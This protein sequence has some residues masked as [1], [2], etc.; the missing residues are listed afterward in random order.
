MKGR[1][2]K[3]RKER[4]LVLL[5]PQTA[6]FKP[7][8][9]ERLRRSGETRGAR[10]RLQGHTGK[11]YRGRGLRRSLKKT[12]GGG[13]RRGRGGGL[14]PTAQRHHGIAS[15]TREKGEAGPAHGGGGTHVKRQSKYSLLT[16]FSPPTSAGLTFFPF[17]R[18][19]AQVSP[20]RGRERRR[21]RPGQVSTIVD[22]S[23]GRA[24]RRKN[25]RLLMTRRQFLQNRVVQNMQKMSG[26]HMAE[27]LNRIMEE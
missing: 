20:F 25:L 18:F 4:R 6:P 13:R 5:K 27:E 21:A 19:Q 16:F 3:E 8:V 11:G 14:S 22:E 2:K 10:R 9:G 12:E 23:T 7:Q 26:V 17:F 1:G 24:A 15:A